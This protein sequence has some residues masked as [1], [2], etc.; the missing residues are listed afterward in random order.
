M[1]E[2]GPIQEQAKQSGVGAW[3]GRFIDPLKWRRGERLPEHEVE[4]RRWQR[5]N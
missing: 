4:I 3:A 1:P 5:E 2:Y